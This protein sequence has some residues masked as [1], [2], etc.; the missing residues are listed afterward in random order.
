MDDH[1]THPSSRPGNV[2]QIIFSIHFKQL[3]TFRG[4]HDVRSCGRTRILNNDLLGCAWFYCRSIRQEL[5][6][7]EFTASID[8]VCATIIIKEQGMIMVGWFER[9]NLPR[10]F[11]DIFCCEDISLSGSL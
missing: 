9:R 2:E 7:S 10:P 5:D 4:K 1:R 11:L 8:H 3:R 6:Q